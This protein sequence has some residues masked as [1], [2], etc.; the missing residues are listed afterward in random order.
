MYYDNRRQIIEPEGFKGHDLR[1]IL[2]DSK[3]LINIFQAQKRR[4]QSKF[5]FTLAYN[6]NSSSRVGSVYNSFLEVGVRNFI[7]GCVSK[8]PYFGLRGDEFKC[9]KELMTFIYD[10]GSTKGIKLTD[11]K[12]SEQSIS[13]LKHRR[14]I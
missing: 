7:K 13:N 2:L 8:V 9:Y 5:P 1:N 6:K 11:V 4:F 10:F 3:P 14:L 12:I